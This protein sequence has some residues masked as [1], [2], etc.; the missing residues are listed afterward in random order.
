MVSRGNT[1]TTGHTV[2]SLAA[3][4]LPSVGL[5]SARNPC[6]TNPKLGT[7]EIR[8]WRRGLD[9]TGS[10]RPGQPSGYMGR[11]VDK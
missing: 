4:S 5:S 9:P 8:A 11:E 1:V 6:H 7:P 3:G 2:A 10:Y